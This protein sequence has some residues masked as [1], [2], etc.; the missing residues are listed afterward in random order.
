MPTD[1]I[2]YQDLAVRRKK[3]PA[4]AHKPHVVDKDPGDNAFGKK[5]TDFTLR[6]NLENARSAKN[7]TRKQLADMLCVK[8]NLIGLWESGQESIPPPVITRLERALGTKI[9]PQDEGPKKV[10][11]RT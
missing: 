5:A 10:S 7:L 1:F 4:P 8:E 3:D 2:E 6:K 9:R 11:S